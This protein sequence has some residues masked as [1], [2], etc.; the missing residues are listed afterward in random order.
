MLNESYKNILQNYLNKP[1]DWAETWS[2][3]FNVDIYKVMHTEDK[4]PDYAYTINNQTLTRN[5]ILGL[6]YM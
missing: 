5:R 3:M 2:M 1:C 6:L 4:K